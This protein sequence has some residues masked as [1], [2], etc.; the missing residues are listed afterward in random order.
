PRHQDEKQNCGG[1]RPPIVLPAPWIGPAAIEPVMSAPS[2][3]ETT[4]LAPRVFQDITYI[5]ATPAGSR[6]CSDALSYLDH[7]SCSACALGR[8][9]A[10][11]ISAGYAAHLCR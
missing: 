3:A 7:P 2:A 8:H 1:D 6:C 5:R 11:A 4:R 9:S 10:L